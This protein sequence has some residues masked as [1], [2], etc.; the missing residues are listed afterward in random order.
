VLEVRLGKGAVLLKSIHLRISGAKSS[1]LAVRLVC[2]NHCRCC[3]AA[4]DRGGER[5]G[6]RA[7]DGGQS[8]GLAE[9]DVLDGRREEAD[10]V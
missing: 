8:G 7:G 10:G 2:R 4:C 9:T 1:C 6:V 5:Y 3:A